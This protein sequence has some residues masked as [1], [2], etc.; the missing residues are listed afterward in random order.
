[1]VVGAYCPTVQCVNTLEGEQGFVLKNGTY[2]AFAIP[3]EFATALAGVN[4]KGVVM[5]N[6]VDAAELVYTF[7]ATP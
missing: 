3:G 5:G 1:V 2:T 6:Y 4:N 7:L